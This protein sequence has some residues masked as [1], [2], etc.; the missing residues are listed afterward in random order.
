MIWLWM[1][2]DPIK[3]LV[4][5]TITI[6]LLTSKCNEY[7]MNCLFG[8]VISSIFVKVLKRIIGA[9]RPGGGE[10]KDHG[11][12]SSH[13][14]QVTFFATYAIVRA[15]PPPSM[16][17]NSTLNSYYILIGSGI[18]SVMITAWD[19][20][21]RSEHS[22]EQVIGGIISGI[23]FGLI[24]CI[25]YL[26]KWQGKLKME[27]FCQQTSMMEKS[28]FVLGVGI[29]GIMMVSNFGRRIAG[30]SSEKKDS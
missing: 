15:I 11:F 29:L 21:R 6:G 14:H 26:E 30:G 9:Q 23:G 25:G 20:L 17:D 28:G 3:S 22:I 4:G 13:T 12:P 27:H 16:D 7:W 2:K 5:L 10:N 8:G 18:G 19:R 1:T 24:F